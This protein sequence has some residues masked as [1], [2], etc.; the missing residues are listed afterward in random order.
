VVSAPTGEAAGNPAINYNGRYVAFE[1]GDAV[2]VR[3]LDTGALEKAGDHASQPSLADDGREIAFQHGRYVY[4]RNLDTGTTTRIKGTQ[5]SLSG[6]G[7]RVAYVR[8]GAVYLREPATGTT[9]LI[10]VDV[11][12]QR[13]DLPAGHPSVN[14]DG[15]IVAFESA[16]PDLVAGDTNGVSDVFLRTVQ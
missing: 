5:P 15:T 14:A 16:S 8:G 2:Y 3:D 4:V 7:T 6:N 10:S 13:N 12:G 9:R 1:Q 11:R